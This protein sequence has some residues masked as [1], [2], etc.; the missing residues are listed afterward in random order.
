MINSIKY[1]TNKLWNKLSYKLSRKLI[2]NFSNKLITK[3]SNNLDYKLSN[4][5]SYQFSNNTISNN[6][7]NSKSNFRYSRPRFTSNK[8]KRINAS[9]RLLSSRFLKQ[10]IVNVYYRQRTLTGR[11]ELFSQTSKAKFRL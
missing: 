10:I 9:R 6:R 5:L 11:K 4:K 3:L 2:T 8:C 1:F 7:L